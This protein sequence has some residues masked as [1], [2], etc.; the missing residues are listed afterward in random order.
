M[1]AP[2]ERIFVLGC[3]A[4]AKELTAVLGQINGIDVVLEHLPGI[5]HNRPEKIAP[6]IAKRLADRAGQFDR[7]ILGYADCGTGGALD[8]LIE[9]SDNIV[10]LPGAHCY[11]FFAGSVD[12]AEM[13]DP[14]TFYLT[15]YLARHFD[16]FVWKGLGLDRW[17]HLRDE[18]F[19]NYRRV[20]YLAQ[21]PTDDLIRRAQDAAERLSLEFDQVVTGL[22]PLNDS[23]TIAFGQKSAVSDVG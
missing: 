5:L 15:D 4:I 14:Y 21:Q 23:L 8:A 3:G 19:G 16:L 10:R 18:Y 17:P 20:V 9:Q 22:A 1:A 12:F 13:N 2:D 6:A 7:V 11:E